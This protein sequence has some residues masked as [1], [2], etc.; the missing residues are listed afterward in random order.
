[1][2]DVLK[3][4]KELVDENKQ[5]K[6]TIK[7]LFTRAAALDA[8]LRIYA[9]SSKWK[10]TEDGDLIIWDGAYI[11]PHQADSVLSGIYKDDHTNLPCP[12]CG[13]MSLFLGEYHEYFCI[14]CGIWC[15]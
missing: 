10:E 2:V 14:D 12:I 3:E 6:E 7:F 13:K 5:L 4:V 1:M 9:D 15:S 8:V 11:G